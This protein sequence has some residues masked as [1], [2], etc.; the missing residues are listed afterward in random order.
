MDDQPD[1]A[2][3]LDPA[4]ERAAFSGDAPS[5]GGDRAVVAPPPSAPP[6]PDNGFFAR[7]VTGP[8]E[9]LVVS[10]RYSGTV[11]GEDNT[12]RINRVE[13][14]S[15]RLMRNGEE[16]VEG[17]DYEVVG[18]GR[19][20]RLVLHYET[21]SDVYREV[22]AIAA[23]YNVTIIPPT[24]SGT[25]KRLSALELADFEQLASQNRAGR[26]AAERGKFCHGCGILAATSQGRCRTCLRKE[27]QF[28]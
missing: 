24:D 26:R 13:N 7:E 2:P 16:L 20:L 21:G 22:P 14:G 8:A 28:G 6:E 11:R 4:D 9:I 27:R 12:V 17:V 19:D 3:T 15:Y 25:W 23:E 1:L 18:Q 5:L 10:A